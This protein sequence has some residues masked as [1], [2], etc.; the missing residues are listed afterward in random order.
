M[1]TSDYAE[2]F[3]FYTQRNHNSSWLMFHCGYLVGGLEAG[4]GDLVH[5]E[6]LMVSF[7]GRD[8]GR[9]GHQREMNTGIGHQ[10]SLKLDLSVMDRIF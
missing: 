1:I 4:G 7:L 8:D 10:V 9:V 2:L 3:T 6:L 5:R